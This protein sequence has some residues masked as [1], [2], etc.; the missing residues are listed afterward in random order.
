MFP[1]ISQYYI[2]PKYLPKCNQGESLLRPSFTGLF[3]SV[4]Y[5]GNLFFKK[6]S[7]SH[8]PALKPAFRPGIVTILRSTSRVL[9]ASSQFVGYEK[10]YIYIKKNNISS[11]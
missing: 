2:P 4:E 11:F 3:R 6:S 5:F 8:I 10:V 9:S 1:H 7:S